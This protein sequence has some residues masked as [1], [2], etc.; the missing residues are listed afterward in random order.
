MSCRPPS[1]ISSETTPEVV[2]IWFPAWPPVPPS[3]RLD[4]KVTQKPG[5]GLLIGVVILPANGP[6][7]GVEDL[8][9]YLHTLRRKPASLRGKGPGSFFYKSGIL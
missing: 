5:E 7:E 3:C 9:A 4:P 2:E 8:S 6:V 1:S